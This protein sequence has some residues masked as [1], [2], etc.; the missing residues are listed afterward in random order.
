ME[1][2]EFIQKS[3]LSLAF[4]ANSSAKS[5]FDGSVRSLQVKKE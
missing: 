1:Y 4:I 3:L 2:T 5:E